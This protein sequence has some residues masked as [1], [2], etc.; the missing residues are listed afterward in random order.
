MYVCDRNIRKMEKS[1]ITIYDIAKE[2]GIS[3]STVSRA[4]NNS[5]SVSPKTRQEVA[6]CAERLGYRNNPFAA[7]LRKGSTNTIGVIVHRLDSLFISSFLSGAEKAAA[8]RGYQLII[9]QSFEDADKEVANAKTMLEKRVDGLLVA[10]AKNSTSV[11]HFKPFNNFGIPLVFFDRVNP[12]L[13]CASF[14]IDNYSAACKV[15]THL[16]EQG[17]RN[18]IHATIDSTSMVYR[19]RER[20]FNETLTRLNIRHRTLL[21]PNIDFDSGKDLAN[22]LKASG[23]MPDGAFFSNDMSATGFIAGVQE[24][25]LNVPDDVAVVG[26]N[27]DITSRIVRPNL[28][29]INY[30]ANELG[31]MATNHIIDH[32]QGINNL[33][34][35]N[36]VVLKSDLIVRESSKRH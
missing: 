13:D 15:A 31:T 12:N 20:G 18:I 8:S 4:L 1:E 26:F 29:T 6:D 24:L 32:L 35:T 19:E 34:V 5:N 7:N 14:A 36:Q 23:D 2:L 25:G 27:N 33:Y 21:M 30:P 11:A 10:T 16:A 3:A 9:V 22:Q 28:T 17:C